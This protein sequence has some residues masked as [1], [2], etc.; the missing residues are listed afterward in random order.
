MLED[1]VATQEFDITST[2]P[3][4]FWIRVVSYIIDVLIVMV[5]TVGAM[6]MKSVPLYLVVAVLAMLYKPLLEGLL[7]A[8][9]GK[10]A[11]GLK[12]VNDEGELIGLVGGFTRS[13]LFIL[14]G[15]PGII[16]QSKIMGQGISNFDPVA[17]K[18]F[19]AENMLL[20]YANW[21]FTVVVVVACIMVAFTARKRGLHDMIADTYVIYANK[22]K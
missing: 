11:L 6:F 9:A 16:M 19:Q 21:G 15:I 14:G 18:E 4:G 2:K 8:T 13:A 3:A 12:V 5:P 7:G 17:M 22:D 10:L 1:N 20:Q